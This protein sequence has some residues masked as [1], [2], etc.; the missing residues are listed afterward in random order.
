LNLKQFFK[1]TNWL[2][3]LFAAGLV[4]YGVHEFN[5]AGWIPPVIEHIYDINFLVDEKST[6]GL[7]LKALFGYN[8]NPSFTETAAYLLYFVGLGSVMQLTRNPKNRVI[9]AQQTKVN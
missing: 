4:A 8:G 6:V 3:V 9:A 2:L 5:E 7:F 1:V